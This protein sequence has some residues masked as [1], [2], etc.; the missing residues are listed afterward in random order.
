MVTLSLCGKVDQASWDLREKS[1]THSPQEGSSESAQDP[2]WSGVTVPAGSVLSQNVSPLRVLVVLSAFPMQALE[3]FERQ[4][5]YNLYT[6]YISLDGATIF[7][8]LY[9]PKSSPFQFNS[10][11]CGYSSNSSN[12]AILVAFS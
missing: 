10:S 2:L 7:V 3:H 12:F 11:I 8:V 9:V 1:L 4:R 5:K 6:H